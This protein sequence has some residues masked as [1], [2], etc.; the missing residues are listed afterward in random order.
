[1]IKKI[2]MFRTNDASFGQFNFGVDF[3]AA[4]Y[5]KLGC[6]VDFVDIMTDHFGEDLIDKLKH[7]QYDAAFSSNCIGEA[8]VRFADGE[9]VYDHFGV[10][11]LWSS[12]FVTLRP[13]N[14]PQGYA[15]P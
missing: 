3:M 15:T 7:N 14:M 10:P 8:E 9:N 13:N 2:L 5:E 12:V 1:M 6:H 11:L 4:E